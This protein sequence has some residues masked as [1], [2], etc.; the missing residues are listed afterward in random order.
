MHRS[1][2]VRKLKTV[3]D[4]I[5][6]GADRSPLCHECPFSNKHG[7]PHRPVPGEGPEN[8][9]WIAIGEGPGKTE[10]QLGRPFVGPSGRLFSRVLKANNINREDIWVSNSTLCIPS[11][12]KKTDTELQKARECCKPRFEAELAR[13]PGKPILGLGGIATKA[14]LGDKFKITQV[15]SSLQDVDVDGTGERPV[16]VTYHPALILRG[17]DGKST[18]SRAVDALFLNLVY[19]AGKI[20]ALADGRPIRF[21]EDVFFEA[22]DPERA[23][24]LWQR[25]VKD[26][27]EVG[28][29][30]ID[31]E[32]D[33]KK[34]GEANLTAIAF[35]TVNFGV[36][37]AYE[38]FSPRTKVGRALW[39][40]TV[41]VCTDP[42]IR[43]IYQ[44]RIFDV[45]ILDEYG[46][47]VAG[48][49]DDVMLKHHA[50][51][52]GSS[53]KL[54]DEATQFFAIRPWK[55]EFREGKDEKGKP[56]S[57]E[58]LLE[59]NAKDALC[60]VRLDKPLNQ[61][62]D[63]SKS[64]NAY[65]LDNAVA[66]IAMR[67]EQVGIPIYLP[68]NRE[69]HDHFQEIIKRTREAITGRTRTPEFR[70][71]FIDQ[72][73]LIMARKKRKDDPSDFLSRHAI[74]FDELF[75]GIR[76]KT[77]PDE[78]LKDKG[79]KQFDIGND[80]HIAPYL[81][82]LGYRLSK[83]TPTGKPSADKNVLET[84]THIEEVRTILEFRE[85]RKLDST[86]VAGL[87]IE[88]T[89]HKNWGRVHSS[90]D[91]HKITG[92]WG[93][94][95]NIQNWPKQNMKGRPNLRTQVVA[96]PG[97]LL[98]G[99][100]FAQ[101]E[102]RI[103]GMMSGDPFLVGTFMDNYGK[104]PMDCVPEKEPEKFCPLHD[105]HTVFALE[106]FS[107]FDKMGKGEKKELRDLIKRAEYGGFYGGELSTLY[108]SI[109]KEFPH[110]TMGEVGKV[111]QIITSR[112]PGVGAWH[113]Q[114]LKQA[115]RDGEIRTAISGR[116]RTF[117]LGNADPNVVYNFPVQGTG[118][119]IVDIGVLA[120]DPLRPNDC[121]LIIQGHDALVYECD[122]DD[123]EEWAEIVTETLTQV[124]SHNG[125]EM[126]YPANAG[127]DKCWANV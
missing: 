93:S 52:P 69:L 103:I 48:D 78:F 115:T 83:V 30:A 122:E 105:V 19:D 22:E 57:V 17:G 40:L 50:A 16:I 109:V 20:Q 62:L 58:S 8:P 44:N 104:C 49:I 51:F 121:E 9:T 126:I 114:L 39:D 100:D 108:A 119:D 66:P 94:S 5:V 34:P 98:V 63:A 75:N 102:A 60:T 82:A 92:R 112:M 88:P 37:L 35:A 73:A 38:L 45:Q 117:P 56:A 31:V 36:S 76:K 23:L 111:L 2:A 85:A 47:E 110:V 21:S 101:L 24:E 67:M 27:Y 79:P 54:Q 127:V 71:K 84:L 26:I 72:L 107:G 96:P 55:A 59:Y 29:C 97:R 53:H 124:H 12:R 95:P 10:V 3:P 113:Q 33:S 32:T 90:W 120:L 64:W 80:N 25:V 68:R 14:L 11:N 74:R 87:P 116:R 77:K 61:C 86:F 6:R 81:M 70:E 15:A 91:V 7:E 18:S 43:T 106:V 123:A 4:G 28:S 41:K 46:V 125:V 89:E 42:E 99:A 1:N 13:F 65:M 118:A